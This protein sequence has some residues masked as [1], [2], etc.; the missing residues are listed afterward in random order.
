M[1]P[2]VIGNAGCTLA[3]SDPRFYGALPADYLSVAVSGPELS[4]SR[5][6]SAGWEGGFTHLAVFFADLADQ[7]RGWKGERSF[8]SIEG[9]L[10]ILATHDGRVNLRVL[11]WESTVPDGWKVEAG[12]RLD[13]GEALS[14][15][16][17]GVALLVQARGD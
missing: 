10:R 13:A 9:D 6:V 5:Q 17:T 14:N 3:F 2:V 8:E 15:A 7:W 4:A 12:V 16:A 1:E 11:L